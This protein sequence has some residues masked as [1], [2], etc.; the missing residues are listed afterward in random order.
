MFP[1][2]APKTQH[3]I[4]MGQLLKARVRYRLV[5]F[6]FPIVITFGNEKTGSNILFNQLLKT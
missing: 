6:K 1:I 4:V 5:G 2:D 3:R